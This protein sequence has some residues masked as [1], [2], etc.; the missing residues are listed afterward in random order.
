MAFVKDDKL[1]LDGLLKAQK[2]NTRAGYRM[3]CTELELP[4][5]NE[6][7]KRDRLLGLS[8]TGWQDMV[9]AL[10]MNI[11]NQIEILKKL[12]EVAHDSSKEIANEVE[13]NVPILST[14]VKPEGTLSLL[15]T[16]SSGVHYSHSPYYIRRVRITST[17][18]LVK[19]CEEL[20]YPIFPE[21]GEDLDTCKTKVIEFPVKAPEGR[22]K[23]DVSAIEQLENYKMFMTHYV[24]H[25]VSI[26]VTVKDNEWETVEQWIWDNW[27][28]VVAISFLPLT[29]A[30]YP[31]MPFEACSKEEYERRI[32]EMKPFNPNLLQKY[33]KQETEEDLENDTDCGTGACAIR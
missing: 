4:R 14:T 24:D 27:D 12:K 10:N 6:Q 3:T 2:L 20:G 8:L 33:E 5:W 31:L 11:E 26:T 22:T 15:P 7:Q 9:N 1:D 19:V 29:D 32:N 13:G 21:N 18:P 23:F 17:D 28:D 25:N 16:V 30:V